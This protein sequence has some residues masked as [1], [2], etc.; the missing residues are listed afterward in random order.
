MLGSARTIFMKNILRLLLAVGY[1]QALLPSHT[2]DFWDTKVLTLIAVQLDI[3]RNIGQWC[4]SYTL[5]E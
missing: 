2:Q 3:F 1:K 5:V 4:L